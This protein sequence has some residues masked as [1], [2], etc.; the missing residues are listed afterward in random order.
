M[1]TDYVKLFETN[2]C[3]QTY[4]MAKGVEAVVKQVRNDTL[5]DLRDAIQSGGIINSEAGVKTIKAITNAI[6]KT[7]SAD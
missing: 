2:A 3:K 4:E 1:K 6:N 5:I 7:I